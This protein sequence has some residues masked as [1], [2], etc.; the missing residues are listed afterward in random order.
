MKFAVHPA[1]TPQRH[2]TRL[3]LLLLAA[4][5]SGGAGASSGGGEGGGSASVA[6]GKVNYFPITP[7]FVVNIQDNNS[8]RFMQIGINLMTMD[9]E[10]V[11]AV[12]KHMAP[13][14]HELVMLFSSRDISEVLS[15]EA[16]EKMRQEALTKIQ[17]VL[18]RYADIPAS[19]KVKSEDGKEHPSSVQEV[20]FTSF[21]IQ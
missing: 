18:E 3:A 8:L 17:G 10:V 15:T 19:K 16:R 6:T 11:A 20:L 14:R 1:T 21:V 12:Q 2:K 13:L 7:A 4:L 5:C 9:A